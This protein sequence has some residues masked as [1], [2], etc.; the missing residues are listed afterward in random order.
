[1]NRQLLKTAILSTP[2]MAIYAL[3]PIFILR[4]ESHSL[5]FHGLLFL[6][7]FTGTVWAINLLILYQ[8]PQLTNVR[9]IALSNLLSL[10]IVPL[11]MIIR[12]HFLTGIELQASEYFFPFVMSLSLNAIISIIIHNIVL[13]EKKERADLEVAR[14]QL[15]NMASQQSLLLQQFRPHFM[16]NALST[17]KSLLRE[18]PQEA[19]SYLLKLSNFLRF[20]IEA[21]QNQAVSLEKDLKFASQYLEMQQIRF[22][23]A[24]EFTF[25]IPNEILEQK[26]P[27][28]TLQSL[29]ENAIKHNQFT[30]ENP[31]RICVTFADSF[32]QI[33]NNK[34]PKI[35]HEKSGTG[36]RNLNQRLQLLNGQPLQIEETE[37]QFAIQIQLLQ[38]ENLAKN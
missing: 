25:Q 12:K 10:L 38:K 13:R 37:T 1:M 34:N 16:F 9:R 36:L 8:F 31:L 21:N 19:E 7:L 17:L 33:V 20:S 35:S 18:S 22:E 6:M 15:A 29:F 4:P 11:F 3:M 5:L 14:L 23:N 27:V 32:L 28:F 26:I 30:E 24:I 2:I